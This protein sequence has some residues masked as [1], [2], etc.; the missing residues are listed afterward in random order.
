VPT[1]VDAAGQNLLDPR[2]RGPRVA[3]VVANH[4]EMLAR[5]SAASSGGS[6]LETWAWPT[7]GTNDQAAGFEPRV[8]NAAAAAT[9]VGRFLC[10][11]VLCGMLCPRDVRGAAWPPR[12][13][14]ELGM[15]NCIGESRPAE[16]STWL[17]S[18]LALD[19]PSGWWRS[20]AVLAGSRP[21]HDS[22]IR[23]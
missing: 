11:A 9:A 3:A 4:E 14:V 13:L 17:T 21:R 19:A 5:A 23:I 12:L 15:T 16:P 2:A 6:K 10:E 22:G 7:G 8:A 20:A 1:P 18:S